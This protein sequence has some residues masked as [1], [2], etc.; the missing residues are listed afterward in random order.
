MFDLM[1]MAAQPDQRALDALPAAALAR[2]AVSADFR[3]N[4]PGV[5]IDQSRV[6]KLRPAKRVVKRQGDWCFAHDDNSNT[7][8]G[9]TVCATTNDHVC[10]GFRRRSGGAFG[11]LPHQCEILPAPPPARS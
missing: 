10:C 4:T 2:K 1:A 11:E 3:E 9:C 7:F 5:T 6:G 8:Q